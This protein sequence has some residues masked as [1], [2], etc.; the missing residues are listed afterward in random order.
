MHFQKNRDVQM[1]WFD[2]QVL[3]AYACLPARCAP[4]WQACIADIHA[5]LCAYTDT[6]V[7][8][9]E[10]FNTGTASRLV[11]VLLLIQVLLSI[12]TMYT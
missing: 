2:L 9:Q 7:C 12:P 3:T 11:V 6:S 8:K 5:K 1:R 10:Y 4:G